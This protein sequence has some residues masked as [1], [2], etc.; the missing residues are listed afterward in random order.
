MRQKV[1]GRIVVRFVF[2]VEDFE[3][4]SFNDYGVLDF[5]AECFDMKANS[6]DWKENDDA[7]VWM[8]KAEKKG[9]KVLEVDDGDDTSFLLAMKPEYWSTAEYICKLMEVSP[10][11]VEPELE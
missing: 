1:I 3:Q 2:E 9:L 5:F 10:Q 7:R 6:F 4:M 11:L 8:L